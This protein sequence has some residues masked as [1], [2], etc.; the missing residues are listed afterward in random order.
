MV[1][2]QLYALL[3][4]RGQRALAVKHLEEGKGKDRDD[5]GEEPCE[6]ADRGRAL[7]T[8]DAT[9]SGIITFM[10][11]HTHVMGASQRLYYA[12]GR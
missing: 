11:G 1:P 2:D 3:V 5:G 4:Q 8:G 12:A 9:T 7:R 6:H 10:C